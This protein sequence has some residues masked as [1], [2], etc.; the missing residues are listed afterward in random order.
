MPLQELVSVRRNNTWS[1]WVSI[2]CATA[3]ANV[4]FRP[5]QDQIWHYHITDVHLASY[6]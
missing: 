5:S 6:P 1:L 2:H 3:T 4:I